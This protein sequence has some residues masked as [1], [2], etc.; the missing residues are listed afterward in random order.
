[1]NNQDVIEDPLMAP[2]SIFE[3][4]TKLVLRRGLLSDNRIAELQ[5]QQSIV[6]GIFG[7]FCIFCFFVQFWKMLGVW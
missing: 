4:A 7:T 6:K 5:R 3:P 2:C 1:M